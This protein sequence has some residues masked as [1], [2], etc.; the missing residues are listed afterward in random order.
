MGQALATQLRLALEADP[1]DATATMLLDS[2]LVERGD[3][4]EDRWMLE[5]LR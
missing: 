2:V 1:D 5:Q 4:E 3:T